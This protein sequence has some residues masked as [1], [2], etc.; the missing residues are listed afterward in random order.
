MQEGVRPHL[1]TA[2][3]KF[4][5]ENFSDQAIVLNYSQVTGIKD[6]PPYSP[7]HPCYLK[8]T[9]YSKNPQTLVEPKKFTGKA[10]ASV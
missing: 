6:W 9:V 10:R 5:E 7:D 8:D 1:L 3:F 2:A 4:L